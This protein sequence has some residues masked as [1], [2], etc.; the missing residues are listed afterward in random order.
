[1]KIKVTVKNKINIP[2]HISKLNNG[3]FWQASTV[4]FWRIISPF[5]PMQTGALMRNVK[6]TPKRVRYLVPYAKQNYFK[7]LN[8][9][10]DKHPLATRMW[11]KV[12]MKTQKH[13]LI[14]FMHIFIKKYKVLK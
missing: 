12:A 4:E 5:T 3:N 6:I 10:K 2:A 14:N 13:K 11:D 9:R 7:N 8:P 1:M